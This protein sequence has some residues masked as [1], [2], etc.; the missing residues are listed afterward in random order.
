MHQ[1]G[2]QRA[3]LRLVGGAADAEQQHARDEQG[4]RAGDG[5]GDEDGSARGGGEPAG[6]QGGAAAAALG[7]EGE[8]DAGGGGARGGRGTGQSGAGLAVGDGLGQQGADGH[9]HADADAA[10]DLGRGQQADGALLHG[11]DVFVGLPRSG[12]RG[13]L[14]GGGHPGP[15]RAILPGA[16]RRAPIR[17]DRPDR[18]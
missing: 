4:Y 18:T 16:H 13:V 2:P 5:G 11:A 7:E 10:D 12:C 3:G 8:G 1:S 14:G 17:Q 15:V 6:A 9:R